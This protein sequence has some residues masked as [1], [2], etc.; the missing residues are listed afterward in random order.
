MVENRKKNVSNSDEDDSL[1]KKVYL[2]TKN[3]LK[4]PSPTNETETIKSPVIDASLNTLKESI[5]NFKKKFSTS[6][7]SNEQSTTTTTTTTSN[8]DDQITETKDEISTK[9]NIYDNFIPNTSNT[10][11]KESTTTTTTTTIET[12]SINET[13]SSKIAT[14]PENNNK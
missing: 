9:A 13:S 3:K 5:N 11:I 10:E 6:I 12:T 7:T 2:N 8:N 4:S 14:V 1:Y